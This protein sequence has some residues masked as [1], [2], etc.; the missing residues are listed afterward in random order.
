[1]QFQKKRLVPLF[2]SL[3]LLSGCGTRGGI[4]TDSYC[5]S[6]N[7]IT[8]SNLDILLDETAVQIERHNNTWERKCPQRR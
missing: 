7:P 8:I 1:M 5:L 6:A 3:A 2:L 4:V